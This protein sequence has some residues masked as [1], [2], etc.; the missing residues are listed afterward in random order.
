MEWMF[1]FSGVFADKTVDGIKKS[2]INSPVEVKVVKIPLFPYYLQGFR[3]NGISEPSTVFGSFIFSLII[4]YLVC[5]C[6]EFAGL[7]FSIILPT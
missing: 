3:V 2:G 6:L 7:L 1:H 4:D 5:F